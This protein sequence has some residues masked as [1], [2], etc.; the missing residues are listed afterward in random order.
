MG[1]VFESRNGIIE[2]FVEF[3]TLESARDW[4]NEL[5]GVLLAAST[6]RSTGLIVH[7]PIIGAIFLYRRNRRAVLAQDPNEDVNGIRINI[8]LHRVASASKSRCFSFACMVSITI[9]PD[10]HELNL[11]STISSDSSSEANSLERAES[12]SGDGDADGYTVQISMI[13]KHPIWDDF[14]SHVEKA[15]ARAA[16][17][18]MEWPGGKAYIDFDPRADSVFGEPDESGLSSLEVSVSRALGLDTANEF[19]STWQC[20]YLLVCI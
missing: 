17:D 6:F 12:L 13:R 1:V 8:P 11:I 14:M 19:I 9:S 18:T 15:K 3:D 5:N 4:R 2:T 10:P 7:A 16:T 20:H